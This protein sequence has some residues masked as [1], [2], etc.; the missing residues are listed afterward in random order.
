MS[1]VHVNI[2]YFQR[3]LYVCVRIQISSAP[4]RLWCIFVLFAISQR[5]LEQRFNLPTD[6]RGDETLT[7]SAQKSRFTGPTAPVDQ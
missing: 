4:K 6:S 3:S 1:A 2:C 7:R 5:N